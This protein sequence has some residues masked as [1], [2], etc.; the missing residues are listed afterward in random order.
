MGYKTSVF[1]RV[2]SE[3]KNDVFEKNICK[4]LPFVKGKCKWSSSESSQSKI[5]EHFAN[6]G[7]YNDIYRVD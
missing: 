3:T 7:L 1:I 6:I 5:K 2:N 4:K